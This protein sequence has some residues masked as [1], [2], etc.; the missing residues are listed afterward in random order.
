MRKFLITGILAI[1]FATNAFAA[2]TATPSVPQPASVK[3]L[4]NSSVIHAP[5]VL[6]GAQVTE[7]KVNVMK[8]VYDF[9]VLGGTSGATVVLRD[10]SGGS[11][12]LPAGAIIKQV[13]VDEVTNV[14]V[15]AGGTISLGVNTTTDLL[16]A[17]AGASFSGVIAGVPVGTAATA[18]KVTTANSAVT[19]TFGTNATTAGKLNVF[20]EYY[21]SD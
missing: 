9:A 12:V 2:T 19:A 4:L 21:L 6:L 20:I 5:R 8:A 14:T 15:S 10:A 16:G 1:F 7:K 18:V 11:A 17:T 13:M 3:Q